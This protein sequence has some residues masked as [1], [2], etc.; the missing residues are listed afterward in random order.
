V[1]VD[2]EQ[3]TVSASVRVALP[4]HEAFRVFTEEIGSW[5]V[6]DRHTV[7][8][9]E[10]TVDVRFEPYVG[11]RLV[12][13]HDAVTGEGR[14]MGRVTAW[15]PGRRIEFTDA[16]RTETEVRFEPAG[17]ATV[18][19]IAQRG[20]DRLPPGEARHVRRYGWRLLLG[21]YDDHVRADPDGAHHDHHDHHGGHDHEERAMTGTSERSV[22][23]Q[24][25]TPYLYYQDAGA[26][27]EWL[28]RVLGFREIV[29]YVDDEGVVRESEMQVGPATVQLCGHGPDPGHG[30]GLLLIVHV[31]DVDA[32][33]ARVV[34]AGVDA[35]APEQK[36]YGP[37]TFTVTDPWGYHWD[38]WQ[39]VHD[40]VEGPGGLREIRP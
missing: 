30:E 10:R 8:D 11:G 15:E 39:P 38:F 9:H 18:V 20:L 13:V 22:T 27:L 40:Y 12:D 16:R 3:G 36:P 6:V 14:E 31:D 34:A 26:A 4:P 24:G 29:R 25:L 2:A 17:D 7:V 21:W 33:H 28:A 35:P 23:I 37:R 32:Q 5:Y 19:T 1:S